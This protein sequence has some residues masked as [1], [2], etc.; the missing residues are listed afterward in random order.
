MILWLVGMMGSGKTSAGRMASSHLLVPFWDTDAYVAERMGCSIAQM[1]ARLGEPAFR[2][3][4]KVAVLNLSDKEGIVST[5]G[6]VVLDDA[7]RGAMTSSGPVVWLQT[8]PGIL[9]ERLAGMTDRPGLVESNKPP[10][11]FIEDLL[12][13]RFDLYES[14][15]THSVATDDLTIEETAAEIEVIWN[16]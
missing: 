15:A 4:E 6:G 10:R 7:N 14:V 2:D 11:K 9:E 12:E 16:A 13:E 5:G 8:S 3:M 1:W